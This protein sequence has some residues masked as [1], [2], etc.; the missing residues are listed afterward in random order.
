MSFHEVGY[1]VID[2]S[3]DVKEAASLLECLVFRVVLGSSETRDGRILTDRNYRISCGYTDRCVYR[4]G[5]TKEPKLPKS[6]GFVQIFLNEDLLHL[7]A[8]AVPHITALQPSLKHYRKMD[9]A[10]YKPSGSTMSIPAFESGV[11]GFLCLSSHLTTRTNKGSFRLLAYYSLYSA[12]IAHFY[13]AVH[14][15]LQEGTKIEIPMVPINDLIRNYTMMYYDQPP[16]DPEWEARILT[17]CPDLRFAVPEEIC[18]VEWVTPDLQ[19]GNLLVW[20][21]PYRLEKNERGTPFSGLYISL[22]EEKVPALKSSLENGYVRADKSKQCAANIE[23][24]SMLTQGYK[25]C[26]SS[27]LPSLTGE[28]QKLY[29]V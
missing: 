27:L 23:E 26:F 7:R 21:C 10:V 19:P 4:N 17:L 24:Y 29:G 18:V 6:T 3:L 25:V 12:L 2:T 9:G 14:R 8:E 20:N 16:D 28:E 22:G 13:P 5:N 1:E 11:T 15:A